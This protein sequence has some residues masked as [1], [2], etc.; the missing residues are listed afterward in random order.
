M[1]YNRIYWEDLPSTKTPLTAENMNK[2]DEEIWNIENSEVI[3]NK[4]LRNS[5]I[6][7]KREMKAGLLQSPPNE[8]FFIVYAWDTA[9]RGTGFYYF[10]ITG[11]WSIISQKPLNG[12]ILF[13]SHHCFYIPAGVDREAGGSTR[14]F[15]KYKIIKNNV[16]GMYIEYTN[17]MNNNGIVYKAMLFE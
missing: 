3:G 6:F 12:D 4:I 11:Q 13:H 8:N 14:E 10:E 2:M 16:G 17:G 9:N 15:T 5:G 7:F 1:S